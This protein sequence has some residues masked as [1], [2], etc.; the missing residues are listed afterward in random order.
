MR[1][2]ENV[3]YRIMEKKNDITDKMF[4]GMGLFELQFSSRTLIER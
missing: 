3:Q 2:N 4:T 1:E